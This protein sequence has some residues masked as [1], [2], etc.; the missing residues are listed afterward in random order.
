MTEV[1]AAV[2]GGGPAGLAAGLLLARLGIETAIVF[3]RPAASGADRRTAALFG[4]SVQLL[5]NLGVWEACSDVSAPLR[6]IRIIDDSGRLLRAPESLFSAGEQ[7]LDAFGYN[8]PNAT[9]T[10]A[11][12]AHLERLVNV[13]IVHAVV[14]TIH[15]T[16]AGASL[17]TDDGREIAAELVVGADGRRSGARTAAGIGARTWDYPQTA[18]VAQFAHQRPHH[19]VSTEFHRPHGPLTT[20]PM[21]GGRSSLVWVESHGE[22]QRLVALSDEAFGS[23]LEKR[24]GGLLGS[25]TSVGGRGAFALSALTADVVARDRVA[26]VGEA[27]HV[28][29]PIGAQ[30]LNLGLRDVAMLGECLAAA[31]GDLGAPE[32]LRRYAQARAPDIAARVA[33]IDALNRSLLT[34]FPP[35]HLARGLGLYALGVFGPL[36]R[37][38]VGEGLQPTL[39]TPTAMLPGGLDRLLEQ[40]RAA[41]SQPQGVRA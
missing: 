16:Q 7:G 30:G 21:P 17:R 14:E 6:G 18:V 2:L 36:R 22:A 35:V 8:V 12:A 41:P 28:I 20:V 9:L 29:P 25:V 19:D 40:L 1:R 4:G 39:A 23:E 24:L 5:A 33:A 11:L 38:V 32:L 26:L 31:P 34:R 10:A 3:P 37:L 13:T 27:A 15:L